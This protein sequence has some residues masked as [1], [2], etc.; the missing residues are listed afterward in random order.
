[1]ATI[2]KDDKSSWAPK[3]SKAIDVPRYNYGKC[4]EECNC[5]E[6]ALVK[7]GNG[8]TTY[9]CFGDRSKPSKDVKTEEE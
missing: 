3:V 7:G 9:T 2:D 8:I 6:I 4:G 1:M 5:L